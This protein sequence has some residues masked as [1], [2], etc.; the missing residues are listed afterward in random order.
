MTRQSRRLMLLLLLIVVSVERFVLGGV[1]DRDR[2]TVDQH[3][4]PSERRCE[5]IPH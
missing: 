4:V 3:T 2:C 5:D 1:A